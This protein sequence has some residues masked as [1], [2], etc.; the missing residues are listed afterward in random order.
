M[1]KSF[2]RP[3]Q[4]DDKMA[5]ERPDQISKCA[6]QLGFGDIGEG[7]RDDDHA[8]QLAADTVEVRAQTAPVA[9]GE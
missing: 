4:I 8:H 1:H 2:W 7:V 3:A 9:T 5:L 6:I